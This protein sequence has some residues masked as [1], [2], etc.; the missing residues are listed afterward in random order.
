GWHLPSKA[1]WNTLFTAVGGQSTAGKVL[2]STSG[3]YDNDNGTDAFGFL[4]LPAG[5]RFY[6]GSY[7]GEGGNAYFWN[8]TESRSG[9]AYNMYLYC[10]DVYAYLGGIDKGYGYSVRCLKD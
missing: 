3:W 4:V 5:S 1:E 7:Y 6:Y 10:D 2:K 9:S 8:S